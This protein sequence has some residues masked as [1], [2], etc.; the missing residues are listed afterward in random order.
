MDDCND[1]VCITHKCILPCL[2]DGPHLVSN[3]A[4]DVRKILE[5]D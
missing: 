1:Y 2:G 4:T 5:D 3:W